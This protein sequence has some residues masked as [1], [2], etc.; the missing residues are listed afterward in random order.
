[1]TR[2]TSTTMFA[3]LLI[4]AI[5]LLLAADPLGRQCGGDLD[6]ETHCGLDGSLCVPAGWIDGRRL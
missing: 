6:C 2:R 3:L 4:A 1:M 5:L